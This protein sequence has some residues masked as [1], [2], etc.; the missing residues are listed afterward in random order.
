MRRGNGNFGWMAGVV[1]AGAAIA[2]CGQQPVEVQQA[3]AAAPVQ[4]AP[5]TVY[6]TEHR[7]SHRWDDRESAFYVRWESE[8][9][10]PHQEYTVRVPAEQNDY[11]NWRHSHPDASND[12]H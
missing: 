10:R 1:L 9:K 5:A 2:G 3:P 8:N 11:W 6:D 4:Q 7:D 12:K